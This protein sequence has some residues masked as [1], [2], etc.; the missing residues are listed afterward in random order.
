M[1]RIVKQ[2]NGFKAYDESHG[3]SGMYKVAIDWAHE[4]SESDVDD[5]FRLATFR[6]TPAVACE[7]RCVRLKYRFFFS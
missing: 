4:Y 7:M 1:P 5:F 3:L 2:F 6:T